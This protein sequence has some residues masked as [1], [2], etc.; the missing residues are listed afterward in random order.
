MHEKTCEAGSSAAPGK[1]AGRA[2]GCQFEWLTTN[3]HKG[4]G[5]LYLGSAFAFFLPGGVFAL[6]MRAELARPG[7][8]FIWNEQFNQAFTAHGT[9]MLLLFATPLLAGFAIWI[10]RL[11]IGAPDV[12][13]P[14]LNV[15][16]YWLYLF[17][18]LIV[19]SGLL[20]PS[21]LGG[22]GLDRLQLLS[23]PLHSGVGRRAPSST[24]TAGSWQA[25]I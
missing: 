17:G 11:Q 14:R 13:F 12:A 19:L 9:S 8:Q 10:T 2:T 3:D 21:L 6:V 24:S 23:G 16:A 25:A 5:S 1:G 20:S 22:L 18:S 15:F 4:V 7:L